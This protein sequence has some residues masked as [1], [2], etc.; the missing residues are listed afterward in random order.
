M[1]YWKSS[2]VRHTYRFISR[3]LNVD[4]VSYCFCVS[5]DDKDNNAPRNVRHTSSHAH[6]RTH[7]HKLG[8]RSSNVTRLG[9]LSHSREERLLTL[10]CPSVRAAPIGRISSK[11]HVRDFNNNNNNNNNNNIY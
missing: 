8:A 10:S 1:S 11:L 9:A 6:A 2:S 5:P 7:P 3:H 4:S